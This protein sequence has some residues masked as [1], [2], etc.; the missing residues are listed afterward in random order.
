MAH[1]L[2]LFLKP[3]VNCHDWEQRLHALSLPKQGRVFAESKGGVE[4]IK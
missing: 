4:I 3:L 2:A 1:P